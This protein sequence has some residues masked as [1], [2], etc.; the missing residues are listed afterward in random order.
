MSRS[1]LGLGHDGLV[2]IPATALQSEF[3]V[4]GLAPAVGL[5]FKAAYVQTSRTA[6]CA[7]YDYITI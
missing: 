5:P 3:G 2:S 1:R 6:Q 4:A 7:V